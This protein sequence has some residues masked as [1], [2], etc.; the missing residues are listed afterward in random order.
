MEVLKPEICAVADAPERDVDVDSFLLRA[1]EAAR[2]T[3]AQLVVNIGQM[4][5]TQSF[6]HNSST[7][8]ITGF[9]VNLDQSTKATTAIGVPEKEEKEVPKGWMDGIKDGFKKAMSGAYEDTL[10]K[11][12]MVPAF[13]LAL[14][15]AIGTAGAFM[16]ATA[17]SQ[18]DKAIHPKAPVAITAMV[19]HSEGIR[20]A[21]TL[22]PGASYKVNSKHFALPLSEDGKAGLLD[23]QVGE[24]GLEATYYKTGVGK[25]SRVSAF[26]S[27][28]APV[29]LSDLRSGE[30]TRS[31]EGK[32]AFQLNDHQVLSVEA[33]KQGGIDLGLT[34]T[35]VETRNASCPGS[36]SVK[37]VKAS[38][39]AALEFVAKQVKADREKKKTDEISD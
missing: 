35:G 3:G 31:A 25:P 4:N 36:T 33:N 1:G 10:K 13:K 39:G 21:A 24:K 32:V 26:E 17:L 11:Y 15:T 34:E 23:I 27:G 12:I 22:L 20:S 18:D 7:N 5:S 28:F 2:R 6:T 30:M 14:I 29:A 8:R 37:T 9:R 38:I 16:H 19:T